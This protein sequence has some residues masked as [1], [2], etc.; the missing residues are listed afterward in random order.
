[1]SLR[2]TLALFD[3]KKLHCYPLNI[4]YFSFRP[5]IKQVIFLPYHRHAITIYLKCMV[6]SFV[7]GSKSTVS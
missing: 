2:E 4:V 3:M 5:V 7:D 6:V 1:M